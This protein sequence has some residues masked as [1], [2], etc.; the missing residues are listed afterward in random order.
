MM[1]DFLSSFIQFYPVKATVVL[2]P[3]KRFR[4]FPLYDAN[5]R[6]IALVPRTIRIT[7]YTTY[8]LK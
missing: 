2:R 4:Q 7:F 3:Q 8:D 6:P 5:N 1:I